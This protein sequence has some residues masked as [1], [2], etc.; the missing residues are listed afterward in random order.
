M[1]L[2]ALL[3]LA[4]CAVKAGPIE[5][6][7]WEHFNIDVE[8]PAFGRLCLGCLEAESAD[9]NQVAGADANMESEDD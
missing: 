6:R 5:L 4:G 1:M 7:L 8:V 9:P 2:P 3:F